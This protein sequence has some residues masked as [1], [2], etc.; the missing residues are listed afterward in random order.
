M[1]NPP[2]RPVPL[3]DAP[4]DAGAGAGS[5]SGDDGRAERNDLAR[6][7]GTG[8]VDSTDIRVAGP[9]PSPVRQRGGSLSEPVMAE[10]EV[11][12]SFPS[13]PHPTAH[14]ER[15]MDADA[16]PGFRH[17]WRE[18]Q[19]S[20]VDDPRDAVRRA[21]ALASEALRVLADRLQERKGALDAVR[22]EEGDTERLRL[23]LRDYRDFFDRLLDL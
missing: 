22:D 3:S 23:A 18:V 21:D 8:E 4:S 17:R 20:F 19:S 12:T 13:P 14:P 1:P 7:A 16:V 9:P 5:P 2:H 10:D 11:A 15:F 6:A